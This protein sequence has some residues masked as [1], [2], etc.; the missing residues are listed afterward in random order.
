[1]VES[2]VFAVLVAKM[3]SLLITS[4]SVIKVVPIHK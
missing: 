1:M 4:K 3:I 2:T